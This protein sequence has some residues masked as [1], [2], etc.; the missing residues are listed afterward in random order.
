MLNRPPAAHSTSRRANAWLHGLCTLWCGPVSLLA[1]LPALAIRATG[2]RWVTS[3]G[4]LEV[5]GGQ[6]Y[7]W[8]WVLS[9]LMPI[10]GITLG[11][12]VL[13][14]DA[15]PGLRLRRHEQA[16]VRQWEQWGLVFPLAYALASVHAGL[17]GRGFYRGNRFEVA[18][19]AAE[20]G[21]PLY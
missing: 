4:L 7:L 18:A 5:S 1:L 11:Q 3:H 10:D 12:I 16:H 17:S 9:P 2:G 19:R 14:R 8:L 21:P 6:A 20:H 15:D 13:Y